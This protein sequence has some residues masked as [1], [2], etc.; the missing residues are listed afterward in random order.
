MTTDQRLNQGRNLEVI[1][2]VFVRRGLLPNLKRKN[3]RA[4]VRFHDSR[5][6][7]AA[8]SPARPPAARGGK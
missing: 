1:R 7:V 2:N 8:R 4:G 5:D 3:K 6:R